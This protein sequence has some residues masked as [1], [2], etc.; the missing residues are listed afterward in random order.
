MTLLQV[1]EEAHQNQ[2]VL[3]HFGERRKDAVLCF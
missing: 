2:E 3:G 1:V